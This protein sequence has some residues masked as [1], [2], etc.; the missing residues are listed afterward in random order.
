MI[1]QNSIKITKS[2]MSQDTSDK[3]FS[4]TLRNNNVINEDQIPKIVNT[5]INIVI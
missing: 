1:K 4:L 2:N 3:V 5:Y